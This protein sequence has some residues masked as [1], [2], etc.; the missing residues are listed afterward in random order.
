M[1]VREQLARNCSLH[2]VNPKVETQVSGLGQAQLLVEP[3]SW[4]LHWVLAV[5]A[6][7]WSIVL[8]LLQASIT[9]ANFWL[10]SHYIF[11]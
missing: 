7:T 10:V 11:P 2:Q 3:S 9:F 6:S 4:L 5:G 1:E 8:A